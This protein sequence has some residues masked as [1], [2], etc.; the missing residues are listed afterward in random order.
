MH[1][2]SEW[3][4]RAQ[5]NLQRCFPHSLPG[6]LSGIKNIFHGFRQLEMN[7]S[8][9][10]NIWSSLS[11]LSLWASQKETIC[12]WLVNRTIPTKHSPST[13]ILHYLVV[14]VRKSWVHPCD[15]YDTAHEEDI[16]TSYEMAVGRLCITKFLSE[17]NVEEVDK[18]CISP[19]DNLPFQ[20]SFAY[21]EAL[22]GLKKGFPRQFTTGSVTQ[23]NFMLSLIASKVGF[24]DCLVQVPFTIS[25]LN[26]TFPKCASITLVLLTP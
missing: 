9:T 22:K 15:A 20:A 5:W 21:L 14:E 18:I 6:N 19:S 12:A 4:P 26:L 17:L 7:V 2:C 13:W 1:W 3:G 25:H 23:A 24:P 10:E 16:W 8:L 11:L